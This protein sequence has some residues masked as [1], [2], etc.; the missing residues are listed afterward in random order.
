MAEGDRIGEMDQ[1][2]GDVN[3]VNCLDRL[4]SQ[5][6]RGL[7]KMVQ[8]RNAAFSKR[9]T[10]KRRKEIEWLC[11]VVKSIASGAS[12][13]GFRPSLSAS[14]LWDLGQVLEC[15]CAAGSLLENGAD[16]Y[17]MGLSQRFYG[18]VARVYT[19]A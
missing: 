18:H 8:G 2:Q 9:S 6:S 13:P 10:G 12:F 5:S 16:N 19:N 7:D 11:R 1:D 4:Q 3:Q 17:L 15:L 14:Q